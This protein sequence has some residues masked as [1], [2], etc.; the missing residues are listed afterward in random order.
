[1]ATCSESDRAA[2]RDGWV[3]V[4][5]DINAKSEDYIPLSEELI[6]GNTHKEPEDRDIPMDLEYQQPA[7]GVRNFSIEEIPGTTSQHGVDK[8]MNTDFDPEEHDLSENA[9]PGYFMFCSNV[10]QSYENPGLRRDFEENK[11]N[12]ETK[13]RRHPMPTQ[14]IRFSMQLPRP[15]VTVPK[16]KKKKKKKE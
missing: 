12:E 3:G 5:L 13:L 4:T 15:L 1:L 14:K 9:D 2:L 6:V 11:K 10:G 16:A 7:R 8:S